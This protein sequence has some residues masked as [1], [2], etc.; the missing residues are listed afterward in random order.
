M[1]RENICTRRDPN[2]GLR[3]HHKKKSLKLKRKEDRR[4]RE[5]PAGGDWLWRI[6]GIFNFV[7]KKT[8]GAR[9]RRMRAGGRRLALRKRRN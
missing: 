6:F 8:C 1:G 5:R 2:T 7:F 9:E 4:G 3:T